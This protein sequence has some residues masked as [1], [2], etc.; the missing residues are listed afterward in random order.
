MKRILLVLTA[1]VVFASVGNAKDIKASKATLPN[2]RELAKTTFIA[3][4]EKTGNNQLLDVS[5]ATKLPKLV[6]TPIDTVRR[7]L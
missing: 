5:A 4:F 3:P 2:L 7:Y 6:F 1:F